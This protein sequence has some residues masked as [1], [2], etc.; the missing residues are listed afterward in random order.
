MK[1]SG[2]K[3]QGFTIL[4]EI[5]QKSAICKKCKAASCS[6]TLLEKPNSCRGLGEQ[7]VLLV[8]LKKSFHSSSRKVS[9]VS[10][11]ASKS[12]HWSVIQV[13]KLVLDLFKTICGDLDLPHLQ[14]AVNKTTFNNISNVVLKQQCS[15]RKTT[16]RCSR[17]TFRC[18]IILENELEKLDVNDDGTQNVIINWYAKLAFNM[19]FILTAFWLFIFYH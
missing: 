5:S 7:F 14:C 3:L 11:T 10:K 15:N 13:W 2:N 18:H 4:A 1:A 8:I 16:K 17:Q 6:L 12:K 9:T 19:R